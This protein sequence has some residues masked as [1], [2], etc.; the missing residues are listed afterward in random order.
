MV[1]CSRGM[2]DYVSA[3]ATHFCGSGSFSATPATD[4]IGK[5]GKTLLLG[6]LPST[7]LGTT[8]MYFI[9]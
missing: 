5:L 6:I 8:S 1:D 7:K 2:Q 4:L 3:N 9:V